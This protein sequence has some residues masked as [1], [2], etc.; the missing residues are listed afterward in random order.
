MR[1]QPGQTIAVW[2]SSGAA[3]A[4]AAKRTLE[5]Y[6]NICKV[7]VIN[8]PIK[9]EDPDNL[10]F[11]KDVEKW[12][13]IEIEFALNPKYPNASATEVW[14]KRK[15]MSGVS[16][17]PCTL[18]LKKEARYEWERNNH[19]DWNVLGFT[20]DEIHRV[21]NFIE[22]ENPNLL[23]VLVYDLLSKKDCFKII[24]DAGIE[25][26]LSYRLGF[27]NANCRA[28][29]KA[30]SPEYWG[31]TKKHYPLEFE[32]RAKQ[33]REIGAKLV[34][35]KNKRIFLDELKDTDRGRPMKSMQIECG[36]FCEEKQ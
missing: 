34:R 36:I 27:P 29:V 19:A 12:L 1:V 6:G 23:P 21:K 2:F 9:E 14:E 31:H 18:E 22:F 20:I 8:N 3:S 4:V 32:A 30:S 13:G 10:R 7:R 15:F 26:P 33:S 28:C 35:V 24:Q 17:A 16:G 11:L 25:L 5:M